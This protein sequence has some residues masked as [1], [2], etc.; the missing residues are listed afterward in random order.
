[1]QEYKSNGYIFISHSHLDIEKV[2]KIRNDM[3]EAGFDPLCFYLKCLTDK[4]ELEDLIKREIKSREHFVYID[5]P[6][7][8]NSDWV[9]TERDYIDSLEGKRTVTI[10]LENYKSMHEISQI[11]IRGLR[12][13]ISYAHMDYEIAHDIKEKLRE[14]EFQV[15]MDDAI[16]AGQEYDK[17]LASMISDAS[18]AGGLI[19]LVSENSLKSSYVQAE[20]KYAMSLDSVI[21]PIIIDGCKP[22]GKLA[23]LLDGVQCFDYENI[24]M[25]AI[26]DAIWNGLLESMK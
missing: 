13:Y 17:Q 3:E 24:D 25:D 19:V 21:I 8:R 15:L 11:L 23:Y 4:D 14:K 16:T 26:A 5:S 10:P 7:A 12:V 20:V 18:Q 1:M 6:N 2:R 9:K 22:T